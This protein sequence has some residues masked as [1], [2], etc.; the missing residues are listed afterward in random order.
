MSKLLASLS[1]T[2]MLLLCTNPL[3]AQRQHG[4]RPT[5]SGGPL[6][7]EQAAYNVTF[8][9][10]SLDVD[11]EQRAI[12]GSLT[13]NAQIV[14]PVEWF[15]LDLDTAFTITEIKTGDQP[16]RFERRG[17]QIW[18]HLQ[19]SKQPG[20]Q[21]ALRV[22][23]HG[24]PKEAP[25]PPW[26]GGFIWKK[27][28]DGQHW[29][30][31]TV[32][33]DGADLWWPCKDHPSDEP[34]SMA[35]NITVPQPL[36][37]ASNGRL[38][39][40]TENQGGTRTY[41]WFVS[42]PINNYNVALNIAPYRTIEG[43]YTSTTGEEIPITYWLLPENYEKGVKLFP[44]FAQHLAFYEKYLGP[45]PFRVD[46]YGVAE[47]PHLGMEHQTIIAYGNN[48]QGGPYG[49]DWLHH[50]ELGHEWWGNLVSALDW[51]DF[52][53]HEGFCSYMQ[54][55]YNEELHGEEAYHAF[56]KNARRGLRNLTAVAPREPQ[57]TRQR[58]F[59]AP[60]FVQSD[61]D[62]Y[63]KGALILHTLRYLIGKE[64]L[65]QAL[66]R[67][68]YPTPE[69][70]KFT[71]GRQCRFV[72]TDDFL[73]IAEEISG[74]DLDWFFEVYLRQPHLPR[75]VTEPGENTL[76]LR[77]ET[78]GNLPFPMPVEVKTGKGIKRVDMPEGRA[79]FAMKKGAKFEIDPQNWI[80]TDR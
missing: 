76:V 17:G 28:A 19:I 60:D 65:L 2:L 57:T 39:K 3:S 43:K 34:D 36:V 25:S 26:V 9:E 4:A 70:E 73:L 35:I 61:G 38:R 63:G 23:Y 59:V 14:Q 13:V 80:L 32:Q 54:A 5:V 42:T 47:T 8:Y 20:E 46:K 29:I 40:V 45:Y 79:T 56:F 51:R 50:H 21:V 37:V 69:M 12:N 1:F 62:I 72:T 55:L 68:A 18:A 74:R 77:W 44:E 27:T 71:D 10:L 33:M 31:T 30:A 41:H 58:Y 78:P 22:H 64:M 75:L 48:Y 24:K 15:V 6:M 53:I 11:P 67:M 52:W 16:M 66:R 7:P 49:Y